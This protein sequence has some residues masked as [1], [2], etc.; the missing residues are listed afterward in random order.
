[1]YNAATV[2]EIL[3]DAGQFGFEINGGYRFNWPA[4]KQ[5]RDA[6]ITRLNGIYSRML[7]NNKVETINGN[8][9]NVSIN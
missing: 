8:K 7:G 9:Y 4:L 1:M 6:Y 3:H 2:S 5:A